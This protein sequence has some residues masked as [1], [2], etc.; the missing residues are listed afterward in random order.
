M[1]YTIIYNGIIS[2]AESQGIDKSYIERPETLYYD[3]SGNDKHLKVKGSKLNTDPS[4]VF[5]LGGVQAENTISLKDL[6][7]FMGKSPTTELKAKDD[8]KGNFNSILR[9]ENFRKI[10]QLLVIKKWYIHFNACQILYYG[11]VDIV[12]SIDGLNYD[13]F[14]FKALLYEILKKDVKKTFDHFKQFKYPNIKTSEIVEFL[15]GILDMIDAQISEDAKNLRSNPYVL[16]MRSCFEKAKN[17]KALT[18][19]QDEEP[20]VWVSEFVQ[21]YR[22]EIVAFSKKKLV[23]D[24]EKQVQNYLSSEDMAFGDTPLT[25]YCFVPSNTNAMIQI[26]DYLASILRKYIMFLDRDQRTVEMDIQS[27]DAEQMEN[28]KLLNKVLW[29]SLNYNPMF[30]HFTASVHVI[31]KYH[32]YLKEYGSI[33]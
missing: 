29:E 22:N 30:V 18:F 14:E 1:D 16:Y 3:E 19:I 32:K 33:I 21:F 12:D 13:S 28:F 10:L 25:N 23:F 17:Q 7:T 26:S 27:F 8:L 9:K 15:D 11:F 20:H 6:K 2:I 4:L 5:V 24:E 31:R